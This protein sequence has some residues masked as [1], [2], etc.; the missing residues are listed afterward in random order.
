MYVLTVVRRHEYFNVSECDTYIVP[1]TERTYQ[2]SKETQHARSKVMVTRCQNLGNRYGSNQMFFTI[3]LRDTINGKIRNE[4]TNEPRTR[5]SCSHMP[6]Y[7]LSSSPADIEKR[8]AVRARGTRGA[9]PNATWQRLR[10]PCNWPT[11]SRGFSVTL[12][13]SWYYTPLLSTYTYVCMY[14]TRHF[15]LLFILPFLFFL[16]FGIRACYSPL[17]KHHEQVDTYRLID[18]TTYR[19][20]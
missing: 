5:N 15:L 16:C 12:H 10:V 3:H 9:T 1:C 8:Y 11:G 17:Y 6:M 19:S 4:R 14:A 18:V 7:K 20:D 2:T 13:P